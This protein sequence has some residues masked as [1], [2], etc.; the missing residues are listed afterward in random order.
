MSFDPEKWAVDARESVRCKICTWEEECPEGA[1]ALKGILKVKGEG[2]SPSWRK[3]GFVLEREFNF[4]VSE[5]S[6]AY[7]VAEH[8]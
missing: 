8:E 5:R 2:R 4:R 6:L 7:H 1:E 3:I